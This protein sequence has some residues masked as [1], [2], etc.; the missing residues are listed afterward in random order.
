MNKSNVYFMT[1]DDFFS[2]REEVERWKEAFLEKFGDSD[3]EELDGESVELAVLRNALSSLPFLS[4][5]RLVGL[6][7]FL[8][9]QKAEQA[10]LI[11]PL[12]EKIP[13][14][15]VLVLVEFGSPDGRTS[16]YKTISN[17]ATKRLFLKPKGA[18]LS[19][20]IQR[21]SEAHGGLMNSECAAYLASVLGDN[22]F[23][24]DQETQK[25]SLFAEGKPVTIEMIDEVCTRSI[26]KSI[27]ALT[28]QLSAKNYSGALAAL[29]HL[30]N[31]GEEAGFLFSMIV[32]QYRL[33]LEVQALTS[34]NLP[35]AMI[36]RKMDVHP[37]V[38]QNTLRF[39]RN[40]SAAEL[41]NA[42]GRFLEIDRR[43]K[44]GLIPLKPREED[45]YLLAIERVLLEK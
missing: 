32:R 36:A 45:Q 7:N 4:E 23:A 43:L 17:G 25:L 3:L 10:N 16:V 18:Q 28:D 22:L 14:S 9:S 1:G 15:T 41:K 26:Q 31:Q 2:L 27:F 30:Q 39:A 29:R 13:E 12:L 33:M 11:L 24:L 35:A 21:R 8:S 38:V 42:L 40:F 20:W 44:T 34:Q 37:F 5:K 19:T 6:K